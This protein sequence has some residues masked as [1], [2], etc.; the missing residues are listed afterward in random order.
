MQFQALFSSRDVDSVS[1]D[2]ILHDGAGPGRA[3]TITGARPTSGV[4]AVV[5]PGTLDAW[6]D[7]LS[8]IEVTEGRGWLEM[9]DG[10][11]R[12]SLRPVDAHQP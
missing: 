12:L 3:A 8:M 10:A 9:T 5:I 1:I 7:G 6:A 11:T 2:G 4:L